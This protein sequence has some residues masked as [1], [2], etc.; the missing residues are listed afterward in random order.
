MYV[1]S[2]LNI[3][4]FSVENFGVAD[5][6]NYVG[7][8]EEEVLN[9]LAEA[10][11]KVVT[12][13][14]VRVGDVLWLSK[15]YAEVQQVYKSKEG[16]DLEGITIGVVYLT[17]EY[18]GEEEVK[19]LSLT[20]KLTVMKGVRDY[21]KTQAAEGKSDANSGVQSEAV[22]DIKAQNIQKGMV[23]ALSKGQ[24]KVDDVQ[25]IEN[26][27]G[28]ERVKINFT[29]VSGPMAGASSW[30]TYDLDTVKQAYPAY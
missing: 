24:A 14:D 27:D 8:S 1:Y 18:Q 4:K 12:A 22:M 29:W 20:D 28:E 7:P 13:N 26:D 30:S 17:G 25:F 23:L 11:Q 16:L 9:A 6:A 3:K 10:Y 19:E 2:R 21:K 5:S 15:G